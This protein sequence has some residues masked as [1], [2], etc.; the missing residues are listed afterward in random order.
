M[1]LRLFQRNLL[2]I[3]RTCAFRDARSCKAAL[4]YD[5]HGNSARKRASRRYNPPQNNT[6]NNTGMK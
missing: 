5:R 1:T 4:A 3:V 6:P 2:R